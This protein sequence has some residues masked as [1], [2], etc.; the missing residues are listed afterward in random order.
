L[1]AAA[2]CALDPV[3]VDVEGDRTVRVHE[4]V[5][6]PGLF[7]DFPLVVVDA[8]D[9]APFPEASAWGAAHGFASDQFKRAV[10][11]R[12]LSRRSA[13]FR[14]RR[15]SGTVALLNLSLSRWYAPGCLALI[16][17][18]TVVLL[19]WRGRR[20]IWRAGNRSIRDLQGL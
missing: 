4:D 15:S 12:R 19:G 9:S 1:L 11:G 5:H 13:A 14:A 2:A 3:V 6:L 10:G 7:A 8:D 17:Y 20:S 18:A 16:Q